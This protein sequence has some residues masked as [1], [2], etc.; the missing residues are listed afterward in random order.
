MPKFQ[1]IFT[2]SLPEIVPVM[3]NPVGEAADAKA[4]WLGEP[5]ILKT[6]VVKMKRF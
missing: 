1:R 3:L 2:F 4:D 6:K 5:V